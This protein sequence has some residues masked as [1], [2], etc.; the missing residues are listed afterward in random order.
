[1]TKTNSGKGKPGAFA[2]GGSTKMFGPQSAGTQMPGQTASMGRGG[3]KFAAGGK[4]KM[5]GKQSA[6]PQRAGITAGK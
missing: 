4:K 5:F 6:I 2:K 1:M 3:G